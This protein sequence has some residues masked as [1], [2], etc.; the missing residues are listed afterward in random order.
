MK[1]KFNYDMS[2]NLVFDLKNITI[3]GFLHRELVRSWKFKD[4]RVFFA[5]I[6]ESQ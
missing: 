6:T 3:Q 1:T 5:Q 4:K 2:Q